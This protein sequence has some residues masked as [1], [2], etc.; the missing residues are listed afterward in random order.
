MSW[1]NCY[2]QRVKT[3]EEKFW[4]KV[5]KKGKDDCWEWLAGRNHKNYGNF[6]VSIGNSKDKHWIAHR[7]AWKLTY[8]EIP[9]GLHICHHCDNPPCVNPNHLWIGTN[10]DNILDASRK[11]RLVRKIRGEDHHKSK[12][13][14]KEVIEIKHIRKETGLS[15]IK[16]GKMFNV[17]PTTIGYIMRGR[18]WS[19]IKD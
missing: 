8:G 3:L 9:K 16:I 7:M 14:E 11:G 6:Y 15:F 2:R 1:K 5:N 19:H 12:L 10:K 18:T 4:E 13:T 17:H